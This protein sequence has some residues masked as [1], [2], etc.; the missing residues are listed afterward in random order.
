MIR[1]I[2]KKTATYVPY[3]KVA[4]LPFYSHALG[5]YVVLLVLYCSTFVL[6]V[7]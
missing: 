7:Q 5:M 1:V 6:E 4:A 3:V 2:N